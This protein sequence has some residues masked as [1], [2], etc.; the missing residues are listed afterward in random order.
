MQSIVSQTIKYEYRTTRNSYIVMVLPRIF[1][2]VAKLRVF[3]S[4]LLF[5]NRR[6]NAARVKPNKVPTKGK[7]SFINFNCIVSLPEIKV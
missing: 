7:T 4:I 5:D 2:S 6:V 1:L 3:S